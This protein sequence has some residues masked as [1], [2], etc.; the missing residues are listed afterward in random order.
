[1]AVLLL[2]H[3]RDLF[4]ALLGCIV[5]VNRSWSPAASVIAV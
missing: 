3:D 4:A 5:A 2:D 1:M